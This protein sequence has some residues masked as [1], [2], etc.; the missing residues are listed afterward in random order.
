MYDLIIKKATVVD[1]SGQASFVADVAVGDG[2]ILNIATHVEAKAERVISAEGLVLA[3]GFVDVQNHSDSFWNLFDS[4]GLDS[5]LLQGFTSALVGQCGTSLAPLLSTAALRSSQKWHSLS[6]SNFNWT[7]FAEFAQH[8]SGQPFGLNVGSLVG[9]STVRRGLLMDEQR[10][11]STQE[12]EMLRDVVHRALGEGAF[13]VS[14][15][16]AYTH[17][18]SVSELELFD[19]AQAAAAHDALLSVHL[20]S[21]ASGVV[22]EVRQML[23]VAERSGVRLKISHLKIRGEQNWHHLEELLAEIEHAVHTGI[24][25]SFDV[26]PYATTWRPLYTYLPAWATLGG[27]AEMLHALTDPVQYRKILAHLHDRSYRFQDMVVASTSFPMRVVSKTFGQVA[28]SLGVTSEEA[29]L[30]VLKNGGAEILVFDRCLHEE[31]VDSLLAHPISVV[32]TDGGGFPRREDVGFQERLVHPRCYGTS[33]QFLSRMRTTR[34]LSLEIA[35]AKLTGMPA[36]VW[37][38]DDRGIIAVGA[39]ADLVL[40]NPLH[41]YDRASLVDPFHSPT[42]IVHVWVNGV[43]AV[44][45]GQLTGVRNGIFLRKSYI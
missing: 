4:P 19:L 1:G 10:P 31:H 40:F 20:K 5:L 17:E 2:E 14:S 24:D 12:T 15:G 11:L 29:V 34:R 6:G 18:A 38:L 36:R 33:G 39:K 21:E 7:S 22:R 32:A 13:G 35:V 41:I 23:E 45:D 28:Q 42:G 27:R 43:Q 16:L 9:Y 37:G 8:F 3:P 26:Y 44:R 25:V 30:E